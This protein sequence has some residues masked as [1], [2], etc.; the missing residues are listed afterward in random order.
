MEKLQPLSTL[1]CDQSNVRV[2]E[3]KLMAENFGQLRGL[4]QEL[5]VPRD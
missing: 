2:D 3:C 4:T 5:N 1:F